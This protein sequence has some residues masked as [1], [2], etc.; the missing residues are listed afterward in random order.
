MT[1][2]ATV[3]PLEPDTPTQPYWT[4]A[5]YDR[6]TAAGAFGDRRIQLLHGEL[7]EMPPMNA[8]HILA[9]GYLE[10]RFARLRSDVDDRVRVSKPIVLPEDGQPE[11]DL[12]VLRPGAPA[13]P[14]VR[15]VL[16]A[17]EISHATR[18]R[19]L[20]TKLE[21]YLRDGL[22]ELWI[23]DLVERCAWI[24]RDGSLVARHARG[25]GVQLV[26]DGVPEVS[27]DLD[28]L[29]RAAGV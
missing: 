27:I 29:L 23:I 3:S 1:M 13:K 24:Y 17:I 6:A 2:A 28:E 26:A 9:S 20:G 12:A 14:E 4:H 16:L 22:A 11:P 5:D 21:D 7:Y 10:R 8:P 19:D 25:A 18:R 15:D